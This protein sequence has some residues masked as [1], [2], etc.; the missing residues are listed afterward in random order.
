MQALAPVE[1]AVKT[2]VHFQ[3]H[4]DP[5]KASEIEHEGQMQGLETGAFVA[6]GWQKP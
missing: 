2:A 4:D 5:G 1:G 3:M 6:A